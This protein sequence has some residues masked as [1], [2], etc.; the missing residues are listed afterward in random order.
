MGHNH[1]HNNNHNHNHNHNNNNNNNRR[2]YDPCNLRCFFG[3]SIIYNIFMI[4][5]PHAGPWPAV[6]H[7]P[8]KKY[9][10]IYIYPATWGVLRT[11][12][13]ASSSLPRIPAS[14]TL[15]GEQGSIT[16]SVFFPGWLVF[17]CPWLIKHPYQSISSDIWNGWYQLLSSHHQEVGIQPHY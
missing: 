9:I 4:L 6:G 11:W 2:P 17:F 10:Y 14:T 5:Y 16:C 12:H 3:S 1:N 8:K 7:K 15:A 13:M